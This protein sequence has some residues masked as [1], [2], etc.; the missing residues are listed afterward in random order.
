MIYQIE[1]VRAGSVLICPCAYSPTSGEDRA[2]AGACP[3]D[4]RAG[5]NRNLMSNYAVLTV[6]A[7]IDRVLLIVKDVGVREYKT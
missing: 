3:G 5:L 2:R 4:E 7:D 6:N 1:F